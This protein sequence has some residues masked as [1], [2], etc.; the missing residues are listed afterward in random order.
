MVRRLI[1]IIAASLI[2]G[3]S[4]HLKP[5]DTESQ[6]QMLPFLLDGKTTREEILLK[7]GE[8]SGT[9]ESGRIL[10]FRLMFDDNGTIVNALKT[11]WEKT[12]YSLVV[13]FDGGD[14]LK[15]HNLILVR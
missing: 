3:C 11:Y 13:V 12:T 10:S 15:K 4:A 6:Q 2:I 14:V 9:F 1:M 5:M 8:P 7:L